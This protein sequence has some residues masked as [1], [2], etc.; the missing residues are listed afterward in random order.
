MKVPDV[1]SW[2][3]KPRE[4]SSKNEAEY[5][6]QVINLFQKRLKEK[7]F[8]ILDV[9]CGNGRLHSFLRHAGFDVIGLD[10]SRELVEEA[11]KKFPKFKDCYHLKN[12]KNFDLNKKFDV[13]LSWFTSFGYFEKDK[14]NL[15]VLKNISKHLR[16]GGIFLLDIPNAPAVI[17]RI[18]STPNFVQYADNF[19]EI[20][21]QRIETRK[22]T[23]WV[24]IQNFYVKRG[25]DLN[26]MKTEMKKVRIYSIPEI[27]KLLKMAGLHT[28]EIFKSRTFEKVTE[29]DRQMLIVSRKL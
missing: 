21:N 29:H 13:A 14:E 11:R 5:L 23:L 25:K 12:M 24:L 18:T 20:C 26:F 19:V 22:A 8:S 7:Y 17:E 16:K 4:A 6:I 28:I 1:V 2:H 27:T 10:N 3:I 9:A 15:K